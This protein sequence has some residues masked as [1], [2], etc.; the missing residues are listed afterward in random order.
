MLLIGK[1]KG[2]IEELAWKIKGEGFQQTGTDS[3]KGEQKITLTAR[4]DLTKDARATITA[5]TSGGR[6]AKITVNIRV[7]KEMAK[8]KHEGQMDL[9]HGFPPIRPISCSGNP[10]ADAVRFASP[11]FIETRNEVFKDEVRDLEKSFMELFVSVFPGDYASIQ[12]VILDA[13]YSKE[14]IPNLI[15]RTVGR[16]SKTDFLY[17]G[18]H[19]Q[20]HDRFYKKKK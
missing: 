9:G 1:P 6:K 3:F 7:P 14:D 11:F 17:K 16:D 2:N 13:G 4:K 10:Q 19:R 8:V 20:K 15:D 12:E 5:K 18:K